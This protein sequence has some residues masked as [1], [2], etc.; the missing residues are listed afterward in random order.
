M[1]NLN[2]DPL[3]KFLD[4]A[5]EDLL[6]FQNQ[7]LKKLILK[8]Y[9]ELLNDFS[10]GS[11][12]VITSIN[13]GKADLKRV[14]NDPFLKERLRE[15]GL[16]GKELQRKLRIF[17]KARTIFLEKYNN[18]KVNIARELAKRFLDAMDVILDSLANVIPPLGA[19]K[20]FKN[21]IE[22]VI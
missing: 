4:I 20:E 2:D 13:E 6:K 5:E 22:V 14:D 7:Y 18:A 16:T 1:E 3:V 15:H 17:Y 21:S 11:D 8:R 9:T 12:I 19:V 10:T